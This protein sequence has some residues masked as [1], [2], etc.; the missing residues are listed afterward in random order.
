MAYTGKALN[1]FFKTKNKK[2]TKEEIWRSDDF[3]KHD[4]S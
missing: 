3:L 4:L 1:I 2:K